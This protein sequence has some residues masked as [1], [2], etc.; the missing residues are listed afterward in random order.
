MLSHALLIPGAKV[1]VIKAFYGIRWGHQV[2]GFNY[3]TED[4]FVQSAFEGCQRLCE[5]ETTKKE[6][7]T[8]NM[9]K[10]L[11]TKYGGKSS[12]ITDLRFLSLCLLGFAGFLFIEE[13]L[14]VK[15]RPIKL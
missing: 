5:R 9:I 8:S 7:I 1:S 11:V 15:L 3:A 13:L 4:P 12:T 2:I 6:L 10:A 14:D